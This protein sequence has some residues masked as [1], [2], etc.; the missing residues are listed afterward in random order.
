MAK[1]ALALWRGNRQIS[2]HGGAI[3]RASGTVLE[4]LGQ[5]LAGLGGLF[6]APSLRIGVTG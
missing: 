5:G 3:L 6:G 1:A 4:T 2:A